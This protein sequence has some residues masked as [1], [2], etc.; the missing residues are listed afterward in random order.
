VSVIPGLTG[1]LFVLRDPR[2]TSEG[3]GWSATE[4]VPAPDRGAAPPT[5]PLQYFMAA[6]YIFA[7]GYALPTTKAPA[8]GAGPAL[9]RRSLARP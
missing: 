6:T 4:A 9:A 8:H 3:G 7:A 1:D 2:I 5:N